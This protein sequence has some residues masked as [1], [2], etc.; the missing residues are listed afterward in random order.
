MTEGNVVNPLGITTC[1]KDL[2]INI[3]PLLSFD[4]HINNACSKSRQIA[5][6][7]L[8]N[9]IYRSCDILV[10]LFVYSIRGFV[11]PRV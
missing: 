8:S 3:D 4:E 9:I 7:I 5:G 6:M 11:H 10:P 1:E 2:G